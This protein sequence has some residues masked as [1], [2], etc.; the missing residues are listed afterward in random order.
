MA[1]DIIENIWEK[2]KNKERTM[3]R[4]QI[5]GLLQPDIRRQSLQ[6]KMLVWIYLIVLIGTA[7]LYIVNIA[8]YWS[9]PTMIVI[10]AILACVSFVGAAYGLYLLQQI[11]E[12]NRADVPLI[13]LLQKRLQL[14]DEKFEIW[15]VVIALS[16]V[17]LTFA[18]N[19]YV[20]RKVPYRI[21]NPLL[22]IAMT[23]FQFC[24]I[25]GINRIAHY[26]LMRTMRALMQDLQAQVLEQTLTVRTMR[27]T[28]MKWAAI[29]FIIGTLL[30]IWGILRALHFTQ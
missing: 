4:A 29:F 8:A 27:K 23:V 3:S 17:L 7:C 20:D 16:V 28:W 14:L 5:E 6:M 2:G 30:L 24:F 26:P 19:I 22:V 12:S 9:N 11:N 10:I 1:K 13:S 15:Y 21:N 18:V 25:Y